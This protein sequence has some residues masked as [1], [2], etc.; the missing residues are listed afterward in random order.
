MRPV[1]RGPWPKDGR[2][3]VDFGDYV[4]ARRWLHERM[5]W[6]CSYCNRRLEGAH[7]EHV[8]P[9]KP[10]G[11]LHPQR[12]TNWHNF[13]LACSNCNSRKGETDVK[14]ADYFW[15]DKDNTMRAFEYEASGGISVSGTLTP[16]QQAIAR[17]TLRLTGL[18][19]V[20]RLDPSA[21][22]PTTASDP[23]ATD[24]RWERR[25][26]VWAKAADARADLLLRNDNV[27]RKW[28]AR[29]IEEAGYWPIW[30]HHLHDI[31]GMLVILLDL[32]PGTDKACFDAAGGFVQRVKG[33]L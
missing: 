29:E 6:Y 21:G 26:H 23:E 33:K 18:D 10:G 25:R 14:L 7:V 17:A 1:V 30:Y 9:K 27:V 2:V 28:V 19:H 5:G 8:R 12:E 3:K 32:I 11:I 20:P 4:K 15:P 22:V 16:R 24:T 31:P 13:L